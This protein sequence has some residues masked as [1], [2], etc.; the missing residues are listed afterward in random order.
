MNK[1]QKLA[2]T[3]LFI[4]AGTNLIEAKKSDWG[5]FTGAVTKVTNDAWD[6]TKDTFSEENLASVFVNGEAWEDTW[7]ATAASANKT[8]NKDND[9]VEFWTETIPAGFT[10][11]IWNPDKNHSWDWIRHGWD[12]AFGCPAG[13]RA[14]NRNGL[15]YKKCK[16]GQ[17]FNND[18]TCISDRAGTI[19][20]LLAHH[21]PVIFYTAKDGTVIPGPSSIAYNTPLKIPADAT[22]VVVG[23]DTQ[24]TNSLGRVAANVASTESRYVISMGVDGKLIITGDADHITGGQE[25]RESTAKFEV[26]D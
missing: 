2:I 7:K 11:D 19:N 5:K 13:M 3:F 12:E 9:F 21:V 24:D 10:D 26:I 23:P 8:F 6:G 25:R 14:N 16:N 22:Y 4:A 18:G 1:L 20:N 15:C 17:H